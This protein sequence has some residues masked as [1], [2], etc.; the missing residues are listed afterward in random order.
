V[1]PRAGM[2][3]VVKRKIPR[4]RRKSNPYHSALLIFNFSISVISVSIAEYCSTDSDAVRPPYIR[5]RHFYD[6][7]QLYVRNMYKRIC[8]GYAKR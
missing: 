6:S 7:L 3:A 5:D 8:N 4:P 2:D 1:G